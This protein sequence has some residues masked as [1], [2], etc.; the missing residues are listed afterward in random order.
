MSSTT[1]WRDAM[2]WARTTDPGSGWLA[3]PHHAA[4]YGSTVRAAGHRDVLIDLLKD[5]AIAMYDRPLAMRLADRAARAGHARLG[6]AGRRA[7]PG[8][9][10]RPRLPRHRSRA[11]AAAGPPVRIALH[12]QA[13][14]EARETLHSPPPPRERPLYDRLVLGGAPRHRS[15][16]SPRRGSFR[17]RRHAGARPLLLAARAPARGRPCSRC[18]ASKGRAPRTTC[19]ASPTRRCAPASTRSC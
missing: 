3:D 10:L 8:A 9:P 14:G 18:T 16:P 11:R 17:S 12:L 1:D 6:H 5:P 15:C 13:R 19:S 4:T 7:R 2:A